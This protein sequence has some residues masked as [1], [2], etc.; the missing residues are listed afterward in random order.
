MSDGDVND[1]GTISAL[2]LAVNR[3]E[4]CALEA[5]VQAIY[6]DLKRL[7]HRQLAKERQ[8][9]TLNTTAI[10]H[11]AYERL[12]SGRNNWNDRG[13]FLRAASTVMR[14]LLV[15]YARRRSAGKRGSG[16]AP[17]SLEDDRC[18]TDDDSMAVLAMNDAINDI[19]EIDPR[20]ERIIECRYFAGLSVE[21]TAEALGM[22][23]RTV[24]RDCQRAR[25]YLQEAMKPDEH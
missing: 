19:A 25:A 16:I 22:A 8:G 20:L 24:E 17:L 9:H 13:H 11:E 4:D 6:P 10:V 5:L 23:V 12:A 3:G 18:S 21:D 14:H 2:L 15:D 7:A 1:K